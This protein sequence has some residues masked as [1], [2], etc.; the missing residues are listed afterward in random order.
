M[1]KLRPIF[2]G[3]AVI[4]FLLALQFSKHNS[5]ESVAII[6]DIFTGIFVGFGLME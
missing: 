3:L 6:F 2:F 1:N 5:T 4:Y